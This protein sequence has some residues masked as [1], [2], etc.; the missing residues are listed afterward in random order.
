MVVENKYERVCQYY[1]GHSYSEEKIVS[2]V[3]EKKNNTIKKKEK[4]VDDIFVFHVKRF[5]DLNSD[6]YLYNELL[7][8]QKFCDS[9]RINFAASVTQVLREIKWTEEKQ[10]IDSKRIIRLAAYHNK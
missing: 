7:D 5:C 10:K 9:N 4:K 2:G 3:I 8:I 1:N 6:K